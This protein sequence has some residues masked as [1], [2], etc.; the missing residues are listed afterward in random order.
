MNGHRGASGTPDP[1]SK[2]EARNATRRAGEQPPGSAADRPANG[3]FASLAVY[4]HP[5]VLAMLLLG[6]SA[7]LPFLLVFST[8]SAWLSQ[9][10][11]ERAM[12]GMM[13][14]VGLA[15]TIKFFWAPVVDRLPLPGL[16][17]WLGRRRGWMLASQFGVATGLALMAL[18][19]PDQD[20]SVFVYLALLVAFSSATQD[21]VIDAWRIEAV[22]EA[23]QGAMAASYS[24][25]YRIGITVAGAG[26]LW[27]AG[28]FGWHA[29]YLAMAALMSVGMLTTLSI[30]EPPPREAGDAEFREQRVIDWLEARAH[31]SPRLRRA[32]AW[33]IGA[34]VCP[35]TD[36]IARMGWRHAL[37]ILAFIGSYRLTDFTM[38]AMANPFYLEIGYTLQEVAAVAKGFGIVS[39]LLGALLGGA[40]VARLGTM[41][42]LRAGIVLVIATNLGF[43]L[44]ALQPEPRLLELAL[45]VSADNLAMGV[46]GVA[47][48]TYLSGLTSPRY[49]A[50]QYAL[51]SSFWALPGKI[52][53]GGSGFVVD[54]IGWPG[55][56]VYT[57][58]L[59]IPA[60]ILVAVLSRSPGPQPQAGAR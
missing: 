25:G 49:T 28:D 40:A 4:R 2:R 31:W 11:I 22:G 8:L 57:S 42:S 34:V 15:Y 10:Q 41:R 9:A 58:A 20:L 13:S 45:V 60:L 5:K 27:I 18:H 16:T 55:F 36:F 35:F 26:A 37:L 53:M 19:S 32:G 39:Q 21:I 52:A 47:L 30:A 43:L 44:L 12:I 38:G 33:F 17:A 46:A 3:W 59:G 24:L 23:W 54:A 7:G 14:W 6:F 51:F 48:I 56:F 1:A 50:T 29:A